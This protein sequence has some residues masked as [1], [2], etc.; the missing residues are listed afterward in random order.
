[1]CI[2][3]PPLL[4]LCLTVGN[5]GV[6]D[7]NSNFPSTH[8][9]PILGLV[10]HLSAY[11]VVPH[12]FKPMQPIPKDVIV[13]WVAVWAAKKRE[14]AGKSRGNRLVRQPQSYARLFQAAPSLRRVLDLMWTLDPNGFHPRQLSIYV[15]YIYNQNNCL[16]SSLHNIILKITPFLYLETTVSTKVFAVPLLT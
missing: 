10:C 7:I 16:L 3:V 11:K 6:K 14:S 8:V 4:P 13:I 2:W 12:T 1:M 5:L 9:V 15:A